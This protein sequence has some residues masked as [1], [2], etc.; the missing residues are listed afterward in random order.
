MKRLLVTALSLS[1][2]GGAVACRDSTGPGASLSGTYT[3]QTVNNQTP[4]VTICDNL[5]CFAVLGGQLQL[6]A[7]GNFVDQLQ[8]QQQGSL[9]NVQ[10][11]QGYWVLSGNQISLVDTYDNIR[12]DG[13][14]SGSTITLIDVTTG[15]AIPLVYTR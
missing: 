8:I 15:T 9:S 5:G 1:L 14:V 4:P 11:T 3:L 12:L 2:L 7:S 10:T 13:T 6:D